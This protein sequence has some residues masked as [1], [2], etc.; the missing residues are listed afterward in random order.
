MK[1]ES[2]TQ[3]LLWINGGKGQKE[4]KLGLDL[5][6]LLRKLQQDIGRRRWGARAAYFM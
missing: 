2:N 1:F 5:G 4:K 3:R 6:G